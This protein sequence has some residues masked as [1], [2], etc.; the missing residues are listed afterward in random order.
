MRYAVAW[1]VLWCLAVQ[2]RPATDDPPVRQWLMEINREIWTP[3]MEGV[4]TDV[5]SLYLRVRSRDYVRVQEDGRLILTYHDYVDDTRQMMAR[6]REQGT[7]IAID[8]RFEERITDGQTA[9]E[10][11]ISRIVFSYSD[12]RTRTFFS[13]FRTISRKEGETWRV[14]SDTPALDSVGEVEFRTAKALDDVATFLCFRR[15]P[16]KELRCGR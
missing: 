10:R 11:G 7:R 15:Y 3:F 12:G 1:G 8:V 9:F 14:L 6:Y 16:E 13:R 5:D 2:G 4:R